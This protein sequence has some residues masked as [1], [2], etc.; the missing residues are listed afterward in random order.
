MSQHQ[1]ARAVGVNQSVISRLE[2]GKLVGL[3]L[4]HL[5][6]IVALLN[7]HVEHWIG[8]R[9]R[10]L[11]RRLPGAATGDADAGPD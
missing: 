10:P 6:S 9:A 7:G 2:N 4:R 5:G 11:G 1:L 3:R 8:Y